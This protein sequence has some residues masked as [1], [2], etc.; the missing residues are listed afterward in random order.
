MKVSITGFWVKLTPWKMSEIWLFTPHISLP[1]KSQSQCYSRAII[2]DCCVLVFRSSIIFD[3]FL[4]CAQ[5]NSWHFGH[6]CLLL[7]L[8]LD[9]KKLFINKHITFQ[10][11]QDVPPTLT[12]KIFRLRMTNTQLYGR[13]KIFGSYTK[14]FKSI[15][16]LKWSLFKKLS[17]SKDQFF[18]VSSLSSMAMMA[19]LWHSCYFVFL[20]R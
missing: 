14:L 17:F 9:L 12:V 4:L 5:K 20:L 11:L 16:H 13:R 7:V 15:V 10:W 2:L 18:F 8:I 1:G 19:N 3:F 6:K